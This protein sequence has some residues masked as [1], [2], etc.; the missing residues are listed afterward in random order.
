MFLF[1]QGSF[2]RPETIVKGAETDKNA[3]KKEGKK[4]K[5]R[6]NHCKLEIRVILIKIPEKGIA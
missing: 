5:R 3:W 6:R 2:V 4:R 1:C